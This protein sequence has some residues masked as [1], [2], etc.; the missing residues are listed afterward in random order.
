M[1]LKIPTLDD[2]TYADLVREGKELIPRHA[3]EWTNHNAADPGITLV[4]LFAYLT[5]IYLYRVDRISDAI[6]AK[7]LKL[8]LG[9]SAPLLHEQSLDLQLQ[10]AASVVRQPFRAV[11]EADFERLALE[12]VRGGAERTMVAR[13]WCFA[14]R[15]FE[16]PTEE[17][18]QRDRPGHVS[19]L[20]VPANPGITDAEV[21]SIRERIR[22]YIEPRRLLT[23]R[24]HVIG[25][26][27]VDAGVRIRADL[28]PGFV[29][30]VIEQRIRLDLERWFDVRHGGE[31]HSGWAL[32][33]SVYITDIYRRIATIAGVSR[34][35]AINLDVQAPGRLRRS[36][37]GDVVGVH[38]EIG[39]LFRVVSVTCEFSQGRPL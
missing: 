10:H 5:E 22:Q 23:S 9:H 14:R 15:N 16:A 27:Y 37:G 13:A 31:D 28:S 21:Q 26:R 33:R 32:G 38:L 20:F 25:P 30:A 4:E 1:P 8:L 11:S 2:R 18:R 6:K 36:E 34:V 19:L 24:L 17:E 39:E 35:I 7:F 12:A 29:A 3:P